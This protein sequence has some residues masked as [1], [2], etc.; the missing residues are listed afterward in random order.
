[1]KNLVFAAVAGVVAFSSTM[2]FA[3]NPNFGIPADLRRDAVVS[4][5]QSSYGAPSVS[6][7]TL[8]SVDQTYGNP[9][10]N[11]FGDAQPRN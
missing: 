4:D 2:A 7:K 11:R 9:A 1:M 3:E 8:Q 10:A 6:I 5:V